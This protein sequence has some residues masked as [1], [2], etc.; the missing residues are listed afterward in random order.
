MRVSVN[1]PF[2]CASMEGLL[3]GLRIDVHDCLGFVVLGGL[4]CASKGVDA[5]KTV[6]RGK[7]QE[8]VLPGRIADLATKALIVDIVG[9]PCIAV[10]QD[11]A[12]SECFDDAGIAEQLGLDLGEESCAEE[13]VAVAVHQEDADGSDSAAPPGCQSLGKGCASRRA[14]VVSRPELKEIPKDEEM[15]AAI[16]QSIAKRPEKAAGIRIG[17]GVFSKVDIGHKDG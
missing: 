6:F 1:H 11:Q 8:A 14:S 5:G 16:R 13:E 12:G 3:D 7:R 17:R 2:A 9:A 4:T 10:A 15:G